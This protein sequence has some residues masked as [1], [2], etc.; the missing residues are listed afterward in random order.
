MMP[1]SIDPKWYLTSLASQVIKTEAE[2]GDI[3][4]VHAIR[5]AHH[6]S[7]PIRN[8]PRWIATTALEE[9]AGR[10]VVVRKLIK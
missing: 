3:K 1:T 8:T 4:R 9:H 2:I 10:M 7:S 6:A 5:F